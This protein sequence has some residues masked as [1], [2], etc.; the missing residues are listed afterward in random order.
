MKASA[1][2]AKLLCLRG[3]HRIW[4]VAAIHGEARRLIRLHDRILPRLQRGDRIVYL[5]NYL[6][7]GDAVAET[8]DELLEFRRRFLAR[9]G[10][11]ACDIGYLRGAQEEMW[12]KL[13]QLQ[14]APD[15]PG[16]LKWMVDAGIEP[17]LRAYGSDLRQAF[18][19]SRD[20]P[21]TITRWT[22]ALRA[23]MNAVPGH[24]PFFAGLRHAAYTDT[25]RLL[26]VHAA[27]DPA[28][29][30]SEQ[31]DAFWW[32]RYDILETTAPVQGF[33]RIVRGF[34]RDRRGLVESEFGV[35]IDAGAGRG[36]PLLAA[37][38]AADGSVAETIEG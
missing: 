3:A 19:A 10:A 16:L 33:R 11:F 14:F 36:G 34:D 21:K 29:P 24:T 35:S 23:T 2:P 38:F 12:Q 27:L 20:G 28:R 25:K 13:L 26:F 9:R 6:G 5:G 30:L 8:I 18:G 1:A 22:S 17:T 15:P 4:A 37:C 7:H 31:R 32:G